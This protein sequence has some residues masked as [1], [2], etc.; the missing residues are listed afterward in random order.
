MAPPHPRGWADAP[1]YHYHGTLPLAQ[2]PPP[3]PPP[4]PEEEKEE[5]GGGGGP[6][7]VPDGG[8]R[9]LW[10]GGLRQWMDED[11]LYGCFT[12][13]PELVSLVIKRNKQTGR[14]EGFGF[15]NFADHTTADL[16]LRSYNGQDM[17]D[18]DQEFSLNWVFQQPAPDKCP[19]QHF[20]LNWETQ[21]VAPHR[22]TD[23]Y[24]H[25]SIF[26]GDL[27]SDVTNFM[28]HHLFKSRYPSVE[29]AK[30]IIDKATG[31]SKGYGFVF[32]GDVNEHRQA[33]TEMNGAYCS[34]R[35][36]RIR[37]VPNKKFVQAPIYFKLHHMPQKYTYIILP[38]VIWCSCGRV[39]V[40]SFQHGSQGTNSDQDPNN[41]RLFVGCL[42]Q[43]VNEEDLK[44]TFSPYGELVDVKVLEGKGCGFVTY[45]DR[46]SAEEAMRS[47]NGSQ[48]RGNTIKLSWGRR[49]ANKQI[50][51]MVATPDAPDMIL[52]V[53]VGV[54]RILTV[55]LRRVVQ[56]M[57][58][59][60]NSN[61]N[62][63]QYSET[64]CQ[65]RSQSQGTA[66]SRILGP[67][68]FLF[69]NS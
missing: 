62:S 41:S 39:T 31:R 20:K 25:N 64:P 9:S 37:P 57:D 52:L 18:S 23:D 33:M 55:A 36:M 8:A 7:P 44:Q 32:F 66:C 45:S 35:P 5:G 56:D 29:G 48:L 54:F 61:H 21:H 47:L 6:V 34:T 13:S 40:V 22:H 12:R 58:I 10:I 59:T 24:S 26:V 43:S 2:A 63:P 51:G 3:P 15:L 46:A 50:N 60:S 19:D 68:I 27:A 1:P 69:G 14:S 53:L 4:P 28:L 42:D 17:P 65:G 30:I 67:S 49:L 11:Y 16:I 38:A